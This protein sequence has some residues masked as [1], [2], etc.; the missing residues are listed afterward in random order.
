M[1]YR[2]STNSTPL[3]GRFVDAA[4]KSTVVPSALS[5][6]M[7]HEPSSWRPQCVWA[8][9]LNLLRLARCSLPFVTHSSCSCRLLPMATGNGFYNVANSTLATQTTRG[10]RVLLKFGG[11]GEDNQW[12]CT[13]CFPARFRIPCCDIIAV[14]RGE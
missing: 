4:M 6:E 3:Q 10:N 13:C 8:L 1:Q 14:A 12:T 11:P 7:Q 5:H 9:L 2:H